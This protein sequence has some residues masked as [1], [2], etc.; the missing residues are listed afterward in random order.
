MEN[1][2][3]RNGPNRK[4]NDL[5]AKRNGPFAKRNDLN[6]K[7]TVPIQKT[8][9]MRKERKKLYGKHSIIR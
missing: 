3:K 9:P 5:F 2:A 7:E 8:V 4:R 1:L 6:E